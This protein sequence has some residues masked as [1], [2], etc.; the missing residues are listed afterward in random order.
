MKYIREELRNYRVLMGGRWLNFIKDD[1][2]CDRYNEV[3]Y[4]VGDYLYYVV[5]WN[6]CNMIKNRLIAGNRDE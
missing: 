2:I 3:W 5:F 4:G 1:I 6:V